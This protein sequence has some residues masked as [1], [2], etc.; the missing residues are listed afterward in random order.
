MH[1]LTSPISSAQQF[2]PQ[3]LFGDSGVD[4]THPLLRHIRLGLN[5]TG[6]ADPHG[7]S[8]DIIGHGS[9]AAGI[10]AAR[11][12]S[13]KMLRGFVPDAEIHV[14]KV[15]PGGRLSSLLEA[16]DYCLERE[17]DIVNLSLDTLQP[18]AAIEQK[19]EEAAFHGIAC[20]VAAGSSA[21]RCSIRRRRRTPWRSARS[22]GST[23]IPARRGMPPRCCPT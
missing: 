6:P 17:I 22:G 14:L 1:G 8:Q 12:E 11:D 19:L 23:S 18:S 20:I 16:L 21:D 4:T 5:L 15:F 7:W 3:G 13:G 10:I 9:H 2:L